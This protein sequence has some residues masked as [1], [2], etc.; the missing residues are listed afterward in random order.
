MGLFG[1]GESDVEQVTGGFLKRLRGA[2]TSSFV[3][4]GLSANVKGDEPRFK[5]TP[6]AINPSVSFLG[7][8]E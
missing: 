5:A 7:R 4:P 8:N 1:N 6:K 3:E 2:R